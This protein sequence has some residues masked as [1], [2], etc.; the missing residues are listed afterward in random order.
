MAL[1]RWAVEWRFDE[2]EPET[3]DPVTLTWWMHRRIDEKA[4]PP[5]RVVVEFDY[6]APTRQALWMVLDRGEASVCIQHPGFDT[7]VL[8]TTTTAALAKVFQGYD[9][10]GAA[11]SSE[12]IRVDGPPTLVRSLPRWFVWSP[13]VEETALRVARSQK[14]QGAR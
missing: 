3:V 7:D 10:W 5:V 2:L 8:V 14:E 1:G 6:T 13:F 4:L 12:A 11:V 9:T